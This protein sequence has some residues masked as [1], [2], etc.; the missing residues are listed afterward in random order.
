M[1][2]KSL[3][4]RIEVAIIGAG[5]QALTLV[6]HLLQKRAKLRQKLM[7]F[8]PSGA[9]LSQWRHQFAAQDILH[10]RSPAVHHP[11]PDPFALRRFAEN[12]SHE[13]FP[14]YDLPGTQL[15]EEFCQDVIQRWQLQH[16]VYPAKVVQILPTQ[17]LGRPRFQ[18][19]L[20]DGR[21][22][23]AR[24]VVLATGGGMK[25][26]PSWVSQI[27]SPYPP[28][29]LCHAQ[30][31]DLR[32]LNLT[33]KHILIIGGGLSSGHLAMGAITRGATVTLMTRRRLQEKLF[34]A[35]PGWL[36]PKYLKGFAAELNWHHRWQMIQQARN[37]G[38]ITPAMMLKLRRA[39]RQRQL[40]LQEHCQ[41]IKANWQSQWQ[42]ECDNGESHNFDRIW[43]ATGTKFD[44]TQHPLLQN[45][46]ETYPP[47]IV[48]GLPILDKH[49]RIPGY[50]C[51]IMGGLAAL[52][53]GPVAR[54]IYGARMA[55]SRIVPAIVKPSLA[56]SQSY[57]I[58]TPLGSSRIKI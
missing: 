11:D 33:G 19:V 26:F 53:I 52:Q 1:W 18:L 48:K 32:T 23:I 7:V 12:R 4:S 24:K 35:E 49:L 45:I 43:L 17:Q 22:I 20:E 3:P 21:L 30:Q 40:I 56:L 39:S 13:L 58:S 57:Q 27:S 16:Q 2:D 31:V 5:P 15:F 8:D 55:C 10:L 50:E 38:S 25:Q 51:F 28:E 14:P 37:G 29:S 42:V 41:V 34:D 36:G 9:W 44:V 6:T 47:E 54:N 46:L